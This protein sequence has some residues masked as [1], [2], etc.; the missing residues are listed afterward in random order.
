MKEDLYSIVVPVYKSERSLREL[1]DRIDKVFEVI[2]GDF[3][4]ILVEDGGGDNSW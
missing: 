4:L 2:R 1:Y 3:E